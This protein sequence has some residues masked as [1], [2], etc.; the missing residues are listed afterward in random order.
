M[1]ELREWLLPPWFSRDGVNGAVLEAFARGLSATEPEAA[2]RLLYL[3]EAEGEYL[4]LHGE[5]YGIPRLK[6][7]SDGEYRRRI[8]A[9]IR[10]PRSTEA[11][12][13]AALE[14]A[15]GVEATVVTLVGTP[16]SP[17]T[18][19]DGTRPLDGTWTLGGDVDPGLPVSLQGACD[20]SGR[21]DLRGGRYYPRPVH[22]G[23]TCYLNGTWNLGAPRYHSPYMSRFLVDVGGAEVPLRGVVALVER[24][25]AAGTIPTIRA[26][27]S[28][29]LSWPLEAQGYA[30]QGE[31]V[32]LD[33]TRPLDGTWT[34]DYQMGPEEPL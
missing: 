22:L 28:I 34:L 25:R 33:G 21:F 16:Q 31:A 27:L 15:F 17:L 7:E 13:R 11:A 19:L 5:V 30:A 23:G 18:F 8:I 2:A 32:R 20:L 3:L 12:I 24:F 9:E 1:A 6:G 26:E 10:T 14:A 4:D 29:P